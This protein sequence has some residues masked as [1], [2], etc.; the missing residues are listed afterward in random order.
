MTP[1]LDR[2]SINWHDESVL[3]DVPL[4]PPHQSATLAGTRGPASGRGAPKRRVVV[5]HA[6]IAAAL[7]VAPGD[8]APRT[9]ENWVR[10]NLQRVFDAE[11]R[12][13]V[14][15]G[16]EGRAATIGEPQAGH[17]QLVILDEI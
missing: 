16:V 15:S 6:A 3:I 17:D 10:I 2:L 9:A 1:D 11:A 5:R 14:L 4:T 8:L 7:G 13:H 12:K